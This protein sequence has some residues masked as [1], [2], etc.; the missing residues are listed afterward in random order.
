[1]G[2]VTVSDTDVCE[3]RFLR[4]VEDS[5]KIF[6]VF[7]E[8]S[9]IMEPIVVVTIVWGTVDFGVIVEIFKV[10]NALEEKIVAKFDLV[11][12]LLETVE[13]CWVITFAGLGVINFDKEFNVVK[14][15]LFDG[16]NLSG[17]VEGELVE[18]F[19]KLVF[20]PFE[21]FAFEGIFFA[22]SVLSLIVNDFLSTIALIVNPVAIV[23]IVWDL[24]KKILSKT[25]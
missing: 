18:P 21:D 9:G 10:V 25:K 12:G 4:I 7:D 14:S 17:K 1:M 13:F 8:I 20:I 3:L 15:E 22:E 11:N 5:D 19:E 6:L 23:E 24:A 16:F 2:V